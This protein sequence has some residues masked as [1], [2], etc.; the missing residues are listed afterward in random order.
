[1]LSACPISHNSI[2]LLIIATDFVVPNLLDMFF[3]LITSFLMG[4]ESGDQFLLNYLMNFCPVFLG[5]F[6][7][8][9][10]E[11]HSVC[12]RYRLYDQL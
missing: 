2:H 6:A 9:K 10:M 3:F 8:I 11:T 5:F 12:L 4:V 7:I 1:M